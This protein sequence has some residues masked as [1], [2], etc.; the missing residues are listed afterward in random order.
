[1]WSVTEI[2][3]FKVGIFYFSIATKRPIMGPVYSDQKSCCDS[4]AY[5]T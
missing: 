1:M 4:E 2:H 5:V 3:N